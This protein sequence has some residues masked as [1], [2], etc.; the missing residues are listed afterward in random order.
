MKIN[1]LHLWIAFQECLGIVR[2]VFHPPLLPPEGMKKPKI[3]PLTL[4]V[5]KQINA[6]KFI[7]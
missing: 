4:V 6:A 7:Q 3:M 2:N 5:M 1:P